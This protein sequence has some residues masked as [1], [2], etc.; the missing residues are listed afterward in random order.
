MDIQSAI[1]R[2]TEQLPLKPRQDQLSLILKRLHQSILRSMAKRGVPPTHT[3]MVEMLGPINVTEALGVLAE[4]DLVVLDKTG[5]RVSGA[6][7]LTL[8]TTPHILTIDNHIEKYTVYA[9]CAL[10]AVA[11]A[12]MFG[13]EVNIDSSCRV[14]GETIRIQMRG[15]D[16]LAAEPIDVVVGIAWQKPCGVAAHSMCTEMVFIKNSKIAELW[17]KKTAAN[18]SLFLLPEAV[19]FAKGFFLPLLE[20]SG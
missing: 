9:M 2:L 17:Q 6:Y 14:S 20:G 5:T 12:P 10:D 13:S 8:E 11:V 18:T 1:D 7:P 15:L 4:L 16:I 3:E 19:L